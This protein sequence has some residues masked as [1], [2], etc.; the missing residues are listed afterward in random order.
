MHF[1]RAA[2]RPCV[3]TGSYVMGCVHTATN[4]C[5]SGCMQQKWPPWLVD[6]FA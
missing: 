1:A 3:H 6:F 4:G 2:E 5:M